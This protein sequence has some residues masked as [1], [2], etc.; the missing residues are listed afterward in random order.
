MFN[1]LVLSFL[2]ASIGLGTT[3]FDDFNDGNG[4]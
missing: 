2:D 1:T 4:R 3:I